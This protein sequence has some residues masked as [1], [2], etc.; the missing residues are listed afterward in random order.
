MYMY[1]FVVGLYTKGYSFL[2]ICFSCSLTSYYHLYITCT[3]VIKIVMQFH[4]LS[5]KLV[6]IETTYTYQNDFA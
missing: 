1:F 6:L 5:K 4:C 3:S 2:Y